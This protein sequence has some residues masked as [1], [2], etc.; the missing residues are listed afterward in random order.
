MPFALLA[1]LTVL[2]HFLFV[3]FV[4]G[5][6]IVLYRWPRLIWLHLPAVCWGVAI[7][8]GGWICPLTYLEIRWR[9]QGGGL[10]YEGS[11]IQH[12][13]EPLLYPVGLTPQRQVFFGVVALLL[14]VG[15]YAWVWR[16]KKEAE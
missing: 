4:I 1:D 16:K 13:L 6:G 11:F 2:V 8:L 5:G 15:I 14:N 3:L 10:G 7:E 9:R 12:Y